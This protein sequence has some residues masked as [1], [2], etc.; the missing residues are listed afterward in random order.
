M[1]AVID[2]TDGYG[3]GYMPNCLIAQGR[4]TNFLA[5]HRNDRKTRRA[6]GKLAQYELIYRWL[7]IRCEREDDEAFACV[8]GDDWIF[9]QRKEIDKILKA[10]KTRKVVN[11]FDHF[12]LF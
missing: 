12:N 9:L 3:R 5:L 11:L 4:G 2:Y 10:L 6:D 1:D 7:T 8:K